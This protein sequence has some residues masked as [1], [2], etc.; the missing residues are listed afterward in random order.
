MLSRT[1]SVDA[2]SHDL[3]RGRGDPGIDPG[4][5]AHTDYAG[6][7]VAT[8]CCRKGRAL[9]KGDN[10]IG[11]GWNLNNAIHLSTSIMGLGGR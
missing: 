3:Q 1:H 10:P 7:Q 9:L 6:N 11:Q 8:A 4:Y 5:L 2:G